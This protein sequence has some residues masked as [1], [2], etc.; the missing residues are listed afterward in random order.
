M[1]DLLISQRVARK[2][3]AV[4]SQS[5]KLQQALFMVPRE[6]ETG[7]KLVRNEWGD[8]VLVE[9]IVIA[10]E[11][12]TSENENVTVVKHADLNPM[13]FLQD[14]RVRLM[15]ELLEEGGTVIFEFNDEFQRPR[16]QRTWLRYPEASWRKMLVSQPPTKSYTYHWACESGPLRYDTV[17]S[18]QNTTVAD[19]MDGMEELE[20]RDNGPFSFRSHFMSITDENMICPLEEDQVEIDQWMAERQAEM[21]EEHLDDTVRQEDPGEADETE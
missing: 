3:R 6:A 14:E 20:D 16:S 13:F 5:M 18:D 10:N 19:I 4:I 7:W 8:I 9:T 21:D 12:V 1:R 17:V 2:W 15:W 11:D